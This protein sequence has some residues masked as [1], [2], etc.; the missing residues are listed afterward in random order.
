MAFPERF[1]D[2]LLLRRLAGGMSE[3]FLAVRLGDRD[4]RCWVV[5]RPALGERASG[6]SAQS[7]LREAAAL[8]E[9][10]SEG[11]GRLEHRGEI[12]GLPFI[13][14]EHREG[15]TVSA[16]F[17]LAEAHREGARAADPVAARVVTRDVARALAVLHDA[18]WVHCDVAPSNVLVDDAGDVVLL[19]LGIAEKKGAKRE[20][21]MGN[22]GYVAPDVVALKDVA[23]SDDVYALGILWAEMAKGER[24]FTERDVAEAAVR[25]DLRAAIA[26]LDLGPGG[27]ALLGRM[28]SRDAAQRPTAAEVANHLDA[29]VKADVSDARARLADAVAREIARVP[30]SSSEAPRVERTD[31]GVAVG[32]TSRAPPPTLV[33]APSRRAEPHGDDRAKPRRVLP[34]I[35]AGA[36]VLA[37]LVFAFIGG[38]AVERRAS[39][40]KPRGAT[41]RLPQLPPRTEYHLDGHTL[42]ITDPDKPIPISVGQHVLSAAGPKRESKEYEF[43]VSDGDNIVVIGVP[44]SREQKTDAKKP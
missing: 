40:N 19:D 34:L 1:G 9:V 20:A 26:S 29:V 28:L 11:L 22:A 18:G 14:L 21:I 44:F 6:A 17:R 8:E 16:L 10:R 2:Y 23:P 25:P 3:V 31:M 32:V 36:A 35:G 13:V 37:L 38:R 24:L 30:S 41:L 15:S 39:A 42:V 7:I 12:G 5:K 4:G 33:D 27:D 43:Y